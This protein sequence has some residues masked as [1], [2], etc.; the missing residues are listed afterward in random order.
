MKLKLPFYSLYL[1]FTSVWW[2]WTVLV[3]MVVVRILF[4]RI[5]DIFVAGSIGME[6]FSR[7]NQLEIVFSSALVVITVFS[8]RE[9]K[10]HVFEF[11]FAMLTWGISMIYFSYLTPKLITLTKLWKSSDLQGIIS[12]PGI[13]DIQQEHQFFHNLY[14][15]LDSVKLVFLTLMIGAAFWRREKWE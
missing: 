14:I 4:S 15:G 11:V 9:K 1:F 13:P 5:D 6:L 3:D 2:G 8:L 12:A 10:H 7:L